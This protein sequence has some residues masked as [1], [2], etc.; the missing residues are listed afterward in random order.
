MTSVTLQQ[1]LQRASGPTQACSGTFK[2]LASRRNG[3][4]HPIPTSSLRISLTPMTASKGHELPQELFHMIVDEVARSDRPT[5]IACNAVASSFRIPA[6]KKLFQ[7]IT[8]DLSPEH[9]VHNADLREVLV[10]YPQVLA[11]VQDLTIII[12]KKTT[13][14]ADTLGILRSVRILSL[15]HPDSYPPPWE[16]LPDEVRTNILI[17][18]QSVEHLKLKGI[19]RFPLPALRCCSRLRVLDIPQSSIFADPD[20]ALQLPSSIKFPTE[21]RYLESLLVPHPA[22]SQ[23]VIDAIDHLLPFLSISRL[24]RF[25]GTVIDDNSAIHFQSILERTAASLEELEIHVLSGLSI[26]AQSDFSKLVNLRFLRV[27]VLGGPRS[28][29]IKWVSNVLET[30]GTSN[31]LAEINFFV[32]GMFSTLGNAESWREVDRVL[33]RER[34]LRLQRVSIDIRVYSDRRSAEF[35]KESMTTL[36]TSSRLAVKPLFPNRPG[37]RVAR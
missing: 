12:S 22:P 35:L 10:S 16:L 11:L 30:I 2:A 9:E 6:Q 36:D 19:N 15:D 23:R 14:S 28:P 17:L 3:T 7:A 13:T 4:S 37:P 34:H 29:S 8:I 24:R 21:M 1:P 25:H 26:S 32:V 33:G 31:S 20:Y 27:H 5:L 18:L